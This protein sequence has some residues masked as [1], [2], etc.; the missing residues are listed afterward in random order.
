MKIQKL[1]YDLF[2]LSQ[3]HRPSPGGLLVP[4]NYS[5]WLD[6]N[7]R[8]HSASPIE[9]T[10]TTNNVFSSK[11]V[12]RLGDLIFMGNSYVGHSSF[13]EFCLEIAE[14]D[15]LVLDLYDGFVNALITLIIDIP[16]VIQATAPV[17]A[18]VAPVA[19]PH[20]GQLINIT[21][22]GITEGITVEKA[23]VIHVHNGKMWVDMYDN[24]DELIHM[25]DVTM[26]PWVEKTP[27]MLRT[28]ALLKLLNGLIDVP[29]S[30]TTELLTK[31][32]ALFEGDE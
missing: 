13:D 5:L 22:K 10:P 6:T 3:I 9:P 7:G 26:T 31:I 15:G 21:G 29:A 14:I 25:V 23:I 1:A 32:N 8:S 28:E 27:E 2:T 12:R 20:T 17:A 19:L 11:Q 30:V 24:G 4:P 16:P 18:P